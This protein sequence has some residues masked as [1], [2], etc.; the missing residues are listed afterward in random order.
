MNGTL[1]TETI[2][3]PASP[4]LKSGV[5]IIRISGPKSKQASQALTSRKLLEA[6]HAHLQKFY[7]PDTKELVDEGLLL[8]FPAPHSFTGEDV[9][10]LHTHGSI[11]VIHSLLDILGQMEGLRLAEP[12]EFSRRAFENGRMDL[13][14]AEGLAD[15]IEAETQLQAKQALQQ[16]QGNLHALY[17][18]WRSTLISIQARLEAYID[19]PDE[20]IPAEILQEIDH[21]HQ[22]LLDQIGQHLDDD[23]RGERL[24]NGLQVVILGPPN[25]GKSS[26]LNLLAKRDVAI[27]SDIAGTTRDMLEVHLNLGG[28]PI[29]LVDTAGLRSKAEHIEQEGIRRAL[30]RAKHADLKILLLD[31]NEQESENNVYQEA[32]EGEVITAINKV[33]LLQDSSTI[34]PVNGQP[35]LGISVHTGEGIDSLLTTL[36]EKATQLMGQGEGQ[37]PIITRTRHRHLLQQTMQYLATFSPQ[38]DLILAAENLR[39]AARS[40]G[41]IIGRIDVEDILD[42]L[43]SQF[44]IGK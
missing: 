22:Q 12:G 38:Q 14:E 44:C 42:E 30:E 21:T 24:R 37:A 15:L 5:A 19:F 25:A 33:D 39:M 13:T 20:D 28:Y 36:K 11:A 18:G 7:H 26:L 40:L 34:E 35:V 2:F 4:I 16:M 23:A 31:A 43:F 17:D 8:W 6:R 9:I 1:P 3:A 29:T 32:Q 27:V 10:E 41:Q